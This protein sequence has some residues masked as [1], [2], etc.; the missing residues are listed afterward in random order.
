MV[1]YV[2]LGR[3]SLII[4]LEDVQLRDVD[5]AHAPVKQR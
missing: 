4:N 5:L 1:D 2:I 3:W